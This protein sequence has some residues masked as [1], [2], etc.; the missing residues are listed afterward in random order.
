MLAT[1]FSVEQR[2]IAEEF[3]G[4]TTR[5]ALPRVEST[6]A[7][8]FEGIDLPGLSSHPSYRHTSHGLQKQELARTES[9]ALREQSLPGSRLMITGEDTVDRREAAA[10]D[11]LG[12][13]IAQITAPASDAEETELDD[14]ETEAQPTE[15]KREQRGERRE[16]REEREAAGREGNGGAPS[17]APGACGSARTPCQSTRGTRGRGRCTPPSAQTSP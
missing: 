10:G 5:E 14:A 2:V 11:H 15:K 4:M 13:R 6:S 3:D 17:A 9:A 7:V 8:E 1:V 12:D 16:R